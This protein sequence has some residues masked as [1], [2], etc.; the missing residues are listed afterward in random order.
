MDGEAGALAVARPET[1][2]V[3]DQVSQVD[4]PQAQSGA[5]RFQAC[6]IQELGDERT[7]AY[8]LLVDEGG[9]ALLHVPAHP[10]RAEELPEP[11]E[12]REG[13]PELVGGDGNEL[14]GPA[15]LLGGGLDRSQ[16]LQG[17]GSLVGQTAQQ[18]DLV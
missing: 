2:D 8:G 15:S 14:L 10:P 18:V 7:Q 1:E 17:Q 16:L 12:G 5:S 11:L 9:P 6:Q 3:F 4:G 13:R